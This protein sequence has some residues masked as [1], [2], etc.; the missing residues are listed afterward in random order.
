MKAGCADNSRL[1]VESGPVFE[2]PREC[3]SVQLTCNRQTVDW[4]R[5]A[6]VRIHLYWIPTP[7]EQLVVRSRNQLKAHSRS[8]LA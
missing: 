3:A 8:M 6:G 5:A 2:N 1:P 4:R 7:K